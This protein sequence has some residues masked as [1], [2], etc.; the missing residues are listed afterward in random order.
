MSDDTWRDHG[1]QRRQ[2]APRGRGERLCRARFRAPQ[3][4]DRVQQG[5]RR[6]AQP[7]RT[8]ARHPRSGHRRHS[9]CHPPIDGTRS[10]D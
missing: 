6:Q 5:T 1:R 8:Q 4:D 9:R 7:T 3:R 10:Q 2:L